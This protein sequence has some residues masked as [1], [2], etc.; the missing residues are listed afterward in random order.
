MV[1][2]RWSVAAVLLQLLSATLAHGHDES[3][4]NEMDGTTSGAG[5]Q[6]QPGDDDDWRNWYDMDSYSSSP[7]H[8]K[9]VVAHIVFMVLAWFFILPIGTCTFS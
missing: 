6:S 2:N 5:H 4:G 8:T 9:M 7:A 1:P 3:T